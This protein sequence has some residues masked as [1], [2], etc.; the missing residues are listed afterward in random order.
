MFA[1]STG[2][3]HQQQ[4]ITAPQPKFMFVPQLPTAIPQPIQQTPA[5]AFMQPTLFQDQSG[6]YYMLN[7]NQVQQPAFNLPQ[8]QVPGKSPLVSFHLCFNG[9]QSHPGQSQLV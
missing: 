2:I 3:Q 4:A 7:S 8:Q 1:A 6:K 5:G 9:F